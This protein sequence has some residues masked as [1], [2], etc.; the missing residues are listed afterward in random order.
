[1]S[2]MIQI[3]NV[4]NEIHSQL[5][6]RAGDLDSKRGSQAVKDLADLPITRYPHDPF[7][8]RIW[9]LRHNVTAWDA[10]YIAFAE[11]LDATLLTRD[12]RLAAAPGHGAAI[13]LV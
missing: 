3:R 5:K 13:E 1:M 7:L 9:R 11:A 6:A 2:R 4:P 10:V 8:S 12:E